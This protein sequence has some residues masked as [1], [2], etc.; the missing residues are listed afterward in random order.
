MEVSLGINKTYTEQ[1][2][3]EIAGFL[4]VISSKDAQSTGVNRQ[5]S[6]E[7]KFGR[8]IRDPFFSE[9]GKLSWKPFVVTPGCSVQS[10]HRDF[11]FAK[12]IRIAGS[13]QEALRR[14]VVKQLYRI[15]LCVFPYV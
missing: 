10:F 4:A 14:D 12:K 3:S 11:V 13:N 6:M 9:L 7:P 1:R 8:K 5:R 15:M 2:N